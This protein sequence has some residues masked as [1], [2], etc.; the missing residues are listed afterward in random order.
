[1]NK[2]NSFYIY[3]FLD[4]KGDV[5]YIGQTTN[6]ENRMASHKQAHSRLTEGEK[7][8][9][10]YLRIKDVEYFEVESAYHMHILEIHMISKYR[11][12]FNEV[13]KYETDRFFDFGEYQWKAYAFRTFARNMYGIYYNK[14]LSKSEIE[15]KLIHDNNYYN[16]V[17]IGQKYGDFVN[18]FFEGNFVSSDDPTWS[19]VYYNM[20]GNDEWLSAYK[21]LVEK[22]EPYDPNSKEHN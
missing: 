21:G 6:M 16:I 11:P 19:D 8:L 9:E 4:E 7:K 13:L 10:L 22:E 14:P 20:I 17:I 12:H 15:Y 5:L 1:M 18:L 2:E 3:R